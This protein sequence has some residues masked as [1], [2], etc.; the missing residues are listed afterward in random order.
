MLPRL[1]RQRGHHVGHR[2]WGAHPHAL[3]ALPLVP[4]SAPSL[5]CGPCACSTTTLSQ[6]SRPT[7]KSFK[8][9]TRRRRW[10]MLGTLSCLARSTVP[11]RHR[12]GLLRD[13]SLLAGPPSAS[14]AKMESSWCAFC[15]A[16]S[17]VCWSLL[18][19]GQALMC[20][21]MCA[22]SRKGYHHKAHGGGLGQAH[23]PRVRARRHGM[24]CPLGALCNPPASTA[25]AACS[26][27]RVETT[28]V[29]L[30]K[31]LCLVRPANTYTVPN[32]PNTCRA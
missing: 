18:T 12:A 11:P 29:I 10:T 20:S 5:S 4:R 17:G 31:P 14:S 23:L 25:C 8:Q 19:Q 32:L 2:V 21:M 3:L 26:I 13:R 9:S 30:P 7:V 16:R 15:L 28:T 1:T 22:G 24:H 6:R 27:A